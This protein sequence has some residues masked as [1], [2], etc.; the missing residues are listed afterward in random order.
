MN[1]YSKTFISK[2]EIK[3]RQ[4]MKAKKKSLKTE[5]THRDTETQK[6]SKEK[7]YVEYPTVDV[8]GMNRA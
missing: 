5:N 6:T 1:L 7:Q 3:H 4:R 8:I 2:R